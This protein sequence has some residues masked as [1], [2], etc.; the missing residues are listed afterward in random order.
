M[1][2]T[3]SIDLTHA[4]G[5]PA[6]LRKRKTPPSSVQ[7]AVLATEMPAAAALMLD[8]A[9][10]A[11]VETTPPPTIVIHGEPEEDRIA[12]RQAARVALL[13]DFGVTYKSRAQLSE[14]LRGVC[15]AEVN[16][17]GVQLAQMLLAAGARV[18]VAAERIGAFDAKEGK[19]ALH[20]AAE[21]GSLKLVGL[22]LR[23]GASV[24]TKDCYGR[25]P[26]HC[27]ASE[28][29][30]DCVRFLVERA[31]APLD[32][33]NLAGWSPLTQAER[34]GHTACADFLK[35]QMM[36]RKHKRKSLPAVLEA[37]AAGCGARRSPVWRVDRSRSRSVG[38]V[39]ANLAFEG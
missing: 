37:N 39:A 36:T 15:G 16:G 28:G 13:R 4:A 19:S 9:T 32:M 33:L 34:S 23:Q 30:F 1:C 22:L 11:I 27:A 2:P 7:S 18:V 17:R 24:V 26:L 35:A 25:T 38:A 3:G 5:L 10:A 8:P 6:A 31:K 14:L 12:R 20:L 21:K 29:R